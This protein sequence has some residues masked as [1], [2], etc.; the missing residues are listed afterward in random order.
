MEKLM[1]S[2]ERERVGGRHEGTRSEKMVLVS[3]ERD[4]FYGVGLKTFTP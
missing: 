2:L 4:S 1:T 3:G